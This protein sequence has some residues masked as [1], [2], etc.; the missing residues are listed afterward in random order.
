MVLHLWWGCLLNLAYSA[1][2]LLAPMINMGIAAVALSIQLRFTVPD[3]TPSSFRLIG[4]GVVYELLLLGL[5]CFA[6]DIVI[7]ISICVCLIKYN[8]V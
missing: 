4:T 3:G 1:P 5:L 6:V 7:F 8:T 2:F